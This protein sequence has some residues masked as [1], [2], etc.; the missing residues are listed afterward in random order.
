[1]SAAEPRESLEERLRASLQ[2]AADAVL[3]LA[4]WDRVR[5]D[6]CCLCGRQ[7]EDVRFSGARCARCVLR[8]GAR[9]RLRRL[10]REIADK[11]AEVKHLAALL[12]KD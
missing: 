8:R 4:R 5:E 3:R 7:M 6:R 11:A 12:E 2:N 9:D 10:R 1:M